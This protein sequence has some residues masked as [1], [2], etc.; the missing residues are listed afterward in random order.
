MEHL[1]KLSKPK[2][3]AAPFIEKFALILCVY[4]LPHK[5]INGVKKNDIHDM[6]A[7]IYV[8]YLY[9]IVATSYF[10]VC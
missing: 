4:N 8:G 10:N 6:N 5:D 2:N 7:I 3:G 9:H 1:R